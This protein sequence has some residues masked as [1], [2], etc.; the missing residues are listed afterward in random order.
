MVDAVKAGFNL[1]VI[2][3]VVETHHLTRKEVEALIISRS[4][5]ALRKN[6]KCH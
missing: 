1:K 4:T 2:D 6:I 3:H 5:L